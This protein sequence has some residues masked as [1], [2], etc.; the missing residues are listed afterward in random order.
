MNTWVVLLRGINVGG[1]NI[2]PM[3]QLAAL[4]VGLGSQ[5]VQT[6]IQSG[7][8]LLQHT[9]SNRQVLSEQ[10]AEQIEQKFDFKLQVLLLEIEQLKQA[11]LSNPYPNAEVEPKILHLFFLASSCANVNFDILKQIKKRQRILRTY[12]TGF[13]FACTRWYW[14]VK[15][16]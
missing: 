11:A 15:V 14:S 1:K 6:Y 4:L 13:L 10:I 7:N 9:E 16:G 2:L 5:N 8:V 3:K 12:R